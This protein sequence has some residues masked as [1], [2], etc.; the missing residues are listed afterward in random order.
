MTNNKVYILERLLIN[1]KVEKLSSI[2]EE[3]WKPIFIDGIK[4]NYEC[5][6]FGRIC[7]LN[8]SKNNDRFILKPIR[9]PNGYYVVTLYLNNKSYR[10]YIH[11]IIGKHFKPIPD[12]YNEKNYT[13]NDLEINHIRGNDK[14]DNSIY[15]IEWVTDS[16]NKIHGYKT[17]LYKKGETNSHSIHK[18]ELVEYICQLIEM[19]SMSI[20]KIAKLTDTKEGFVY[21]ILYKGSWVEIS[22]KYDFSKYTQKQKK[23]TEDQIRHM[24]E[25][26]L[27]GEH[28]F[29]DISEIT[30]IKIKT[31]YYYNKKIH[32]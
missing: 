10:E 29:K 16:D 26:L 4:T 31:V 13:F 15:N 11:R 5:S 1:K 22:D 19:N 6:N 32:S 20:P 27:K 24:K 7:S 17:G 23:Y 2:Y 21:D 3:E 28:S 25:L 8:K 18:K 14:W 12:K 9:L 30:G